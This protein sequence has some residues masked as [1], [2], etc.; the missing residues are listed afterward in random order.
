MSVKRC[1]DWLLIISKTSIDW[2][3]LK[4]ASLLS[5][6]RTIVLIEPIKDKGAIRLKDTWADFSR[7]TF[8]FRLEIDC[9]NTS[10]YMTHNDVIIVTCH[11]NRGEFL[12]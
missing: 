4:S 1:T 6:E 2:S 8:L 12:V 5:E 7:R 3:N 11:C 9:T 10:R